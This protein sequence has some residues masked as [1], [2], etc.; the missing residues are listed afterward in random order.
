MS[1]NFQKILKESEQ[2]LGTLVLMIYDY[3]EIGRGEQNGDG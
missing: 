3:P 2:S 1:G